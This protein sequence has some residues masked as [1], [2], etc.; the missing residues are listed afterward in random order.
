VAPA[1]IGREGRPVIRS[2]TCSRS[3]HRAFNFASGNPE[4]AEHVIVHAGEFFDG[5]TSRQFGFD[6]RLHSF[7]DRKESGDGAARDPASS[8]LAPRRSADAMDLIERSLR[9]HFHY[10]FS[11]IFLFG[12]ETLLARGVSRKGSRQRGIPIPA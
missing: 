4:I 2:D 7:Q 11:L 12:T 1:D 3:A 10:A 8:R 6:R 9:M 5:V